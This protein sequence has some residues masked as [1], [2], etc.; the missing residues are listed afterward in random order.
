MPIIFT[1]DFVTRKLLANR[2]TRDP[3]IIIHGNSCIILYVF[4]VIFCRCSGQGLVPLDSL[5]Q[6]QT[7]PEAGL[8]R[9]TS[10]NDSQEEGT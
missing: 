7:A 8:Q 1:R 2:L 9:H 10:V 4:H 3:K 5:I 6:A